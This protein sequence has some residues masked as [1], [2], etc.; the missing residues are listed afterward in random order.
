MFAKQKLEKVSKCL[1]LSE[2]INLEIMYERVRMFLA[3][4]SQSPAEIH[5][6]T[7]KQKLFLRKKKI[8][9]KIKYAYFW[10]KIFSVGKIAVTYMPKTEG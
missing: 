10:N 7:V 3:L 9:E 5:A 1:M 4:K 2:L 8:H 6:H